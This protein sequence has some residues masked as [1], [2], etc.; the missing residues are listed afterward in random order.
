MNV[1]RKR[2]TSKLGSVLTSQE[3]MQKMR[4]IEK[5]LKNKQ[6]KINVK[7]GKKLPINKNKTKHVEPIDDSSLFEEDNNIPV[8]KIKFNNGEYISSSGSDLEIESDDQCI[9][10]QNLKIDI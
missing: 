6:E 5:E 3:A 7:R 2:L 10:E 1:K 4:Q 8:K 9:D